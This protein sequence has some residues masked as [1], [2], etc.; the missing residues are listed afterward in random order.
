MELN[1]P[2]TPGPVYINIKKSIDDLFI[3]DTETT[4]ATP[5]FL[6]FNN[7]N[8]LQNFLEVEHQSISFIWNDENGDTV[9][10]LSYIQIPDDKNRVELLNLAIRPA[11]QHQGWGSRMVKFYFDL[12]KSKGFKSSKLVTDP[13]NIIAI[14]FYKK[15]G[16]KEQ[17]IYKNYYGKGQDRL[18][19]IK[20]LL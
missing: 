13:K 1:F 6:P 12:M 3:I 5:F 14:N 10:Y 8:E 16:F 19:M 9:G 4:K 7:K 20:E 11:F 17:I 18:L 15:L 2:K